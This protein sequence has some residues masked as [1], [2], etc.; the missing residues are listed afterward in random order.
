MR[1]HY[2]RI[3][4]LPIQKIFFFLGRLIEGGRALT[5]KDEKQ[6]IADVLSA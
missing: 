2:D 4:V 3:K 6:K 5:A 1:L